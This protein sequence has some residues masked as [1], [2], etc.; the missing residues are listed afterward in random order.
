MHD[1]VGRILFKNH[2]Q[3]STRPCI[4]LSN[5][6]KFSF[7]THPVLIN[8]CRVSATQSSER[9]NCGENVQ[10]LIQI[11][12][13]FADLLQTLTAVNRLEAAFLYQ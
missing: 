2:T 13:G 10:V 6:F 12:Y 4:A 3:N 11:T 8:F 1:I 5:N 7:P 9:D